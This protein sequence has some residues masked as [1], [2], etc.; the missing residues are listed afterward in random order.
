MKYLSRLN[1]Y[2]KNANNACYSIEY[3]AN[4]AHL[5]GLAY[6]FQYE[7]LYNKAFDGKDGHG[8]DLAIELRDACLAALNKSIWE[9][10]GQDQAVTNKANK[11]A[12][13]LR[14]VNA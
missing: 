1:R 7:C 11:L 8:Q 3:K 6:E 10:S 5:C 9:L 2:L 12:Y 4:V 13:W 14:A